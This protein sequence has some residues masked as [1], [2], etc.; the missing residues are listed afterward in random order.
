MSIKSQFIVTKSTIPAQYEKQ[1]GKYTYS[2]VLFFPNFCVRAMFLV[3]E[4]G[5][6]KGR[7]A[8]T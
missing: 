1:F 5:L 7:S 4:Y 2:K 8:G 6:D 3:N